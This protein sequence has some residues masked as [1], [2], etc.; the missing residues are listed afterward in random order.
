[1]RGGS[2]ALGKD[3]ALGALNFIGTKL[4]S[5]SSSDAWFAGLQRAQGL[6]GLEVSSRVRWLGDASCVLRSNVS[7]NS[8]DS[9]TWKT[10]FNGWKRLVN[11]SQ[12]FGLIFG[13]SI[14]YLQSSTWWTQRQKVM[15][16]TAGLLPTRL[17]E[18]LGM[19]KRGKTWKKQLITLMAETGHLLTVGLIICRVSYIQGCA[20]VVLF[21]I[22]Y[23]V[24]L[25]ASIC[26]GWQMQGNLSTYRH[27]VSVD[28]AC[29]SCLMHAACPQRWKRRR[30]MT[31]IMKIGKTCCWK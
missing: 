30:M 4:L 15:T 28:G 14:F 22:S 13:A 20:R 26:F 27:T 16:L 18:T 7:W 9:S 10:H 3:F 21:R 19:E 2:F 24:S 12:H 8:S 17:K 6:W 5:D 31:G 29:M 23:I 11:Q 25:Y 1:M